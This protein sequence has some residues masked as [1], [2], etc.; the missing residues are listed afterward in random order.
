M[1]DRR[2]AAEAAAFRG[3]QLGA[4]LLHGTEADLAARRGPSRALVGGVA[5]ALVAAVAV[6]AH[7]YL[8]G[9]PPRGWLTDGHV[10]IDADQGGRYLARGGVLHPVP[11]QT[12][13]LLLSGG[14]V[15]PHVSVSHAE[16]S[17]ATIGAA[18]GS[19][20]LPDA[21]PIV[22]SAS[23]RLTAC[24]DSAGRLTLVIGP[25]RPDR[26]RYDGIVTTGASG[27]GG[28]LVVAGRV[29]PLAAPRVLAALDYEPAQQWKA[30]TGWLALLPTGSQL[31]LLLPAPARP[32]RLPPPLLGAVIADASTGQVYVVGAGVLRPVP[33]A[34][35]ALLV[36]GSGAPRRVPHAQVIAL[37]VGAP[38]G[39]SDLPDG[40]PAVP[41]A[42]AS[43]LRACTSTD[44]PGPRIAS[45]SP[46]AA[47]AEEV[48]GSGAAVR[49]LAP[50]GHGALLRAPV[51]PGPDGVADTRID[52]QHP[53][54]LVAGG[55]AYPI[56]SE[57]ALTDLGYDD[58]LV[59]TVPPAWLTL[60]PAGPPLAAVA[61]ATG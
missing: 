49:V 9:A 26:S 40:R 44:H 5:V 60:L 23:R 15:P 35:S 7:A 32:G 18:L 42:A 21:P 57:E 1:P 59:L 6:G 53:V 14:T 24:T 52:A 45:G 38:Y 41:P 36:A 29:H 48:S 28:D 25:T 30:A 55:Q 3:R 54:L 2:M 33:N 43:G 22:D 8:T 31:S 58:K 51:R 50:R 47:D 56:T 10:V 17:Q 12:S 27:T 34:L 11:N 4:A 13:L 39:F 61:R 37:P 19:S 46:A 20:T 16:L